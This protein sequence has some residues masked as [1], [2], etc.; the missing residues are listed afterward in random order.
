MSEGKHWCP[1]LYCYYSTSTLE[2]Q[3]ILAM[4]GEEVDLLEKL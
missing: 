1:Q 4:V 2:I 3:I